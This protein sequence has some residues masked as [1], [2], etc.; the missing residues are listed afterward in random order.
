M[1]KRSTPKRT[2][3][4]RS[5]ASLDAFDTNSPFAT[6]IHPD[7]TL[8]NDNPEPVPQAN[9]D[10][11]PDSLLTSLVEPVSGH[12]DQTLD[13]VIGNNQRIDSEPS[14]QTSASATVTTQDI[15]N[16]ERQLRE[17]AL[18]SLKR[19]R[20]VQLLRESSQQSKSSPSSQPRT[21]APSTSDAGRH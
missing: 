8:A 17:A 6:Y 9:N 5:T 12:I 14:P 10:N 11:N 18:L 7:Q 4:K 15:A 3:N 20:Y 16:R 13:L 2:A 19:N 1:P 21:S